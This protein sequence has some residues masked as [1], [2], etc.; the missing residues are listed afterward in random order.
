ML[1]AIQDR[2]GRIK[3]THL[4]YRA[5]LSYKQFKSYLEELLEKN[6]VEKIKE[7]HYEYI[8][9]TEPGLKFLQNLRQM[10]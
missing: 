1:K 3:P 9:I 8:I 5:N 6:L 10:K 4:M 7:K 2:G